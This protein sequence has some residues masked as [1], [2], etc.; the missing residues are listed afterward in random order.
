[1]KAPATAEG[2]VLDVFDPRCPS[3]SALRDVT[4]RWGPLILL[5]MADGL[6]RFGDLHRYIGGS[7]ERMLSKTLGALTA[8]GLVVRTTDSDGRPSYELSAGGREVAVRLGE[9]RDAIYAHLAE[10]GQPAES[11]RPSAAAS[12]DA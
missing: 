1:M 8:H 6:T 2:Y 12:A 3:R 10:S 5:A 11:H 7:N 4:G 9:L